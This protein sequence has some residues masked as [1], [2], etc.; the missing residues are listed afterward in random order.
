MPVTF[1]EVNKLDLSQRQ[2]T[3]PVRPRDDATLENYLPLTGSQ[4]LLDILGQNSSDEPVILIHGPLGSGKSHLLQGACHREGERA[5]YLPLAELGGYP[6]EQ[7]LQDVETLE[8]VCLDDVQS[9]LGDAE[10]ELALFNLYNRA[11]QTRC[12]L[13][14]AADAP[15]RVL[16]VDLPD[17]RSRLAW[18]VVF[19]LP[20]ASDEEKVEIL[21]FRAA[22]RGLQ[23]PEEV[24]R[25]VVHRSPRGMDQLLGLL[26]DLDEASLTEKRALSIPFVKMSLGL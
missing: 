16:P 11:Q 12:S 22:R 18:G 10:W 24:A 13:L 19:Q 8:L 17:L 7:V 4:A 21:C 1:T 20:E 15:P 6:P 14:I 2:L 23:M 5:Q 26:D 25:Y 9:V 3:L